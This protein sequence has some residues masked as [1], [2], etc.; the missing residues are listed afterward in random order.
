MCLWWREVGQG[1]SENVLGVWFLCDEGLGLAERTGE[2][3][4]PKGRARGVQIVQDNVHKSLKM[5]Q[6]QNYN[7][8]LRDEISDK[9]LSAEQKEQTVST[10]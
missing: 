8:K 5:P 6:T 4:P 7:R 3:I 2:D 9:T 10:T 1:P